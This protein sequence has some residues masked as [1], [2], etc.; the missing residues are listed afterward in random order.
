MALGG[1]LILLGLVI[2]IIGFLL[3][4]SDYDVFIR[5]PIDTTLGAYLIIIGIVLIL[6]GGLLNYL[7]GMGKSLSDLFIL[8]VLC[9]RV[10]K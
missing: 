7:E 1:G 3:L 8:L 10:K 5:G 6:F 4:L 2:L 9:A